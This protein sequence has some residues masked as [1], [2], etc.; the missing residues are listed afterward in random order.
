M[1]ND[2]WN[3]DLQCRWQSWRVVG[4]RHL[5][6]DLP[7][8]NCCDMGGAIKIAQYLYP[9]VD[10]IDTFSGGQPDTK[11]RFDHDGSEWKAFI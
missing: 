7:D 6:L 2:C 4:D 11:Y 8:M 5:A 9:D 3:K 1:S 10:K